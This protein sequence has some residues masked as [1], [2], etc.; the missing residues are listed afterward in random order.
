MTD[1]AGSGNVLVL[2]AGSSSLKFVLVDP[3][4]SERRMSGIAERLGTDEAELRVSYDGGQAAD[5]ALRSGDHHAAVESILDA[6]TELPTDARPSCVGHRVVHGGEEFSDSV[7]IDDDVIAAIEKYSPLAPLHN[8]PALLGI[9]AVAKVWPDVPQVAVFDTAFHQT[10]PPHAFRYAVP[11]DWY[12]DL[13]V[14]KYGFHGTSHRYVSQ[15]AAA[16]LGRRSDDLAIV[17]AH[18][19]NGC[20]ATAVLAGRSVD[21]TMGL[22]PLEGLV[23]GTRSGD[24]DAGVFGYLH[25]EAGMSAEDVTAKLNKESGIL[26]LSGLTNDMREVRRAAAGGS[27]RATLAVEVFVYRLAKHIAALVVALGR[28]DA[29]V[30]TGGIGENDAAIRARTLTALGFLGLEPDLEANDAHG[31]RTNGRITEANR[32]PV[33][34]VVQT[35]EELMIALDARRVTS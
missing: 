20:S 22:T 5:H 35:D 30:F 16:L 27:E 9:K 2:N 19:G 33:G 3:D 28:L 23:M 6:A 8:P 24:I 13:G 32:T 18:L 26:G 29:L 12:D 10:M 7:L 14:R 4:S 1:A 31:R 21:T 17:V 11:G 15:Q 25:D 34:L